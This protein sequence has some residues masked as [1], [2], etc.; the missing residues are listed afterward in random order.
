VLEGGYDPKELGRNVVAHLHA[1]ADAAGEHD[2]T[3]AGARDAP[4]GTE[5]DR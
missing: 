4:D 3:M 1:L 2:E 5:D